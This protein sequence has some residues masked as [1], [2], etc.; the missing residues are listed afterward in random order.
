MKAQ[1][2]LEIRRN[3]WFKFGKIEV[4][5]H[6]VRS[7]CDLA[8]DALE[9]R[10]GVNPMRFNHVLLGFII[11]FAFAVCLGLSTGGVHADSVGFGSIGSTSYESLP[12]PS[13]Y[14]TEPSQIYQTPLESYYGQGRK[15]PC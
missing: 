9:T 4:D 5:A 3:A 10:G 13:V 1:D 2:V 15:E 14:G 7:L 8:L 12:S 6:Y 11:G